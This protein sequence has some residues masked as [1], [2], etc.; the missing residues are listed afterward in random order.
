MMVVA[1]TG[2]LIAIAMPDFARATRGIQL[3]HQAK[4]MAGAI[5]LA[6]SEAIRRGETIV[7]CRANLAQSDCNTGSPTSDWSQGWLIYVDINNNATYD[8]TI[9]PSTLLAVKAST[10]INIQ[11]NTT[12]LAPVADRISF[13]PA[14]EAFGNGSLNSN[15]TFTFHYNDSDGGDVKAQTKLIINSVGRVRLLNYE[16]CLA[17]PICV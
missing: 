8:P 1:I 5:K 11:I 15:G 17:D 10:N 16:Q 2:V 9:V 3:S 14:G 12:S 4:E 7:M 6:R 13:N